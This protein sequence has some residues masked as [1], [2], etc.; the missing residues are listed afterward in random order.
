MLGC[1]HLHKLRQKGKVAYDSRPVQR[2]HQAGLALLSAK[3]DSDMAQTIQ[4]DP[5][6]LYAHDLQ[7]RHGSAS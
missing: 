3:M 4:R 5:E 1:D 2:C 7:R 6:L